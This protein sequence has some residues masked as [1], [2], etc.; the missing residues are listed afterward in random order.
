MDFST[1]ILEESICY[2]RGI[3]CSFLGLLGSREKLLFAYMYV[4]LLGFP[5]NNGLK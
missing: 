5:D 2:L 4:P 3:R 1:H